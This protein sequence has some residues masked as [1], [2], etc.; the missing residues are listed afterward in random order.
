MVRGYH[1]SSRIGL[2][3]RILRHVVR[4]GHLD[5]RDNRVARFDV[6]V[7]QKVA[8]AHV[9]AAR[10][11][12]EPLHLLLVLLLVVLLLVVRHVVLLVLVLGRQQEA[13]EVRV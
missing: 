7:V 3:P 11:A 12:A 2:V 9:H 4:V 1:S 13:A 6:L 8:A 5:R 10:H